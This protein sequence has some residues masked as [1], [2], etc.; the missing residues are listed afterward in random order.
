MIFLPACSSA[1][2]EDVGSRWASSCRSNATGADCDRYRAGLAAGQAA[3]ETDGRAW[4]EAAVAEDYATHRILGVG[5][6]L[7]AALAGGAWVGGL[8]VWR[9][10]RP[11]DAMRRVLRGDLGALSRFRQDDPRLAHAVG[12]MGHELAS[13][14]RR[15]QKLWERIRVARRGRPPRQEDI[16]RYLEMLGELVDEVRCTV[17]AL[18]RWR[19]EQEQRE[20]SAPSLNVA[21]ALADLDAAMEETA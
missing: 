8:Q 21:E 16:A 20:F 12:H 5:L 2:D 13:I 1:S 6:L 4:A 10:E 15:A 11:E 7:V 14:A 9:R 17:I 19:H 3:G 18:S